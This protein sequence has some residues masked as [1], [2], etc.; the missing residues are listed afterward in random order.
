MTGTP[1]TA[2]TALLGTLILLAVGSLSAGAERAV[3]AGDEALRQEFLARA[4]ELVRDRNY[5]VSVTDHYEV[6]TDDPRVDPQAVAELLESFRAFFDGFWEEGWE[7]HP[8][9]ERSRIYLFFSYYKYN[10]LLTGNKR[11]GSFRPSGHYRPFFDLVVTYS[12]S[13]A[14]GDLPELMVHEAAHQLM[15][16][17]LFGRPALRSPWLSEGMASYFGYTARDEKGRFQ[18]GRI[19]GKKAALVRGASRGR[20]REASA[21][22]SDFRQALKRRPSFSITSAIDVDDPTLFYGDG[23]EWR[24]TAAWLL[25][26][27]LMHGDGGSHSEGFRSYLRQETLGQGGV[28]LLLEDLGLSAERLDASFRDYVRRLKAR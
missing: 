21:R 1:D 3:P 22:L 9:D 7:L 8:Y 19:G 13:V 5:Q 24:Y 20:G 14:A 2:L 26:H 6:K 16:Q 18:A 23:V 15:E 10:E 4:D 25:V 27:F 17:R 12:D 28:D 11:F